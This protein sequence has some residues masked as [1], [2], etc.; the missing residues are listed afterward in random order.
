MNDQLQDLQ[1]YQ[2]SVNRGKKP[3]IEGKHE[4]ER[5]GLYYLDS[6]SAQNI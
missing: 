3:T 2:R 6:Y 4:V 5:F 1:F